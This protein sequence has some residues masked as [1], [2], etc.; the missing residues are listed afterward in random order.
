MNTTTI[1]YIQ[2]NYRLIVKKSLK[3]GPRELIEDA[4]SNITMR[5]LKKEYNIQDPASF[6]SKTIHM[7]MCKY[8]RD[9]FRYQSEQ[10]EFRN[11][12][13]DCIIEQIEDEQEQNSRLSLMRE[14]IQELPRKQR[15]AI[16]NYIKYGK[17]TLVPGNPNT[18]KMNFHWAM[19]TLKD[20]LGFDLE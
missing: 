10:L 11:F 15:E 12:K 19:Q 8:R 6:I 9:N 17:T 7:E 16:E 1:Q 18:N 3:R 5:L 20:R 4:I 14:K 13:S 2:D